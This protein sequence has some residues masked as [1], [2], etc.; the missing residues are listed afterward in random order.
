MHT[1]MRR[2]DNGLVDNGLEMKLWAFS[3]SRAARDDL[4]PELDVSHGLQLFLCR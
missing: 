3:I 2:V 1:L 4:A